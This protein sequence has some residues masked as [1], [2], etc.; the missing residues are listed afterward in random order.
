MIRKLNHTNMGTSDLGWLQSTFHFSFS[1]YFNKDNMKFG[2]LRVINDDLIHPHTG[3]DTHPHRD[4]EIV[5]YVVDGELTHADSMGNQRTLSRRHVQYMSAGKGIL[6]SEH[7]RGDEMLRI[8]QIWIM[9]DRAMYDP[10]YGDHLFEWDERKNKWL[11]IVSPYE[12]DAPIKIH[13][14]ANLYVV[15]L[16]EGNQIDFAVSEDRQAYLAQIEGKGDV[17]GEVLEMRD[18]LESVEEN[19]TIKAIEPSHYLVIEMKKPVPVK[20]VG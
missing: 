10:S 18:A 6:H 15:E 13:Q 14:D 12:G 16:D 19:L 2:K 8:L 20:K 7:N 17:N 1:N 4:M 3:F 9:P 5:S 11:H